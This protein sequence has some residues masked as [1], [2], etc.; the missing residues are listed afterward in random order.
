[1]TARRLVVTADDF[2]AAA[3]VNAAVEQAHRHGVLSAASLMV[4]G[5]AAADAVARARTMPSLRVGLHIVL[6][7]GRP[8]LPPE[9]LPDLV[10]PEGA[11]RTDLV[12][13]GAAIFLRPSVRRQVAREIAAQFEA[14]RATG[15]PLDH[16]NA[17][18]HFH[19]HPTVTDILLAVGPAYGMRAIRVPTEPRRVLARAEPERTAPRRAEAVLARR[20]RRRA[21][22]AG[23]AAPDAVFGLAW[24]GRMDAA[25]LRGLCANLPDGLSEIY[26]HP[27]TGGGFAGAAPD[28]RYEAE[29]DALTDPAVV[30]GLRDGRVRL[31]GFADLVGHA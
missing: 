8:V 12:A 11:L 16:V 28:Y 26:L 3:E 10:G 13:L 22:R 24:S 20:L 14:F 6:A 2:G 15:L 5:A 21:R 30:A 18:K 23:V 25:R 29:L 9:A 31:G 4:A 1:M 7:E 19:L 27:A 17:H